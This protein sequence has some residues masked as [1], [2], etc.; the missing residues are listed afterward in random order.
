MFQFVFGLV[1]GFIIGGFFG[2][3]VTALAVACKD[4]EDE[5]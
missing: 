2:M 5:Y 1:V 3:C 4:D